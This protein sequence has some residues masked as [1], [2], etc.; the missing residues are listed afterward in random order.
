ML[1]HAVVRGLH[2]GN[3]STIVERFGRVLS[4]SER[5]EDVCGSLREGGEI[6]DG[7]SYSCPETTYERPDEGAATVSRWSASPP[8]LLIRSRSGNGRFLSAVHHRSHAHPGDRGVRQEW[9]N[10]AH[11]VSLYLL[12]TSSAPWEL[13]PCFCHPGEDAPLFLSSQGDTERNCLCAVAEETSN[14]APG[15]R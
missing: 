9:E 10:T 1:K 4:I 14:M 3:H 12:P 7:E 13:A 2:T 6:W 5:L 11:M 15:V 8:S